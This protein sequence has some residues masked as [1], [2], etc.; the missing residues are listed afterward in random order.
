MKPKKWD[1]EWL[2]FSKRSRAFAFFALGL[3]LVIILIKN[4]LIIAPLS[5]V[6]T[7]SY[8]TTLSYVNNPKHKTL[9]FETTKSYQKKKKQLDKWKIPEEPF[10][11]NTY[12]E[13]DWQNIG[14][15]EK[16]AN[17]IMNFADKKGG[18]QHKE[19]IQK[20]F[21]V[22]DDLYDRLKDVIDLPSK[23]MKD[24]EK[25]KDRKEG[26]IVAEEQ[27][28]TTIA[29]ELNSASAEDLLQ[30]KG[31]GPFF[32]RQI[33]S[34]RDKLGGFLDVEQ[35]LEVYKMS[36]DKLSEITPYIRVDK[37]FVVPM[38]LNSVTFEDLKAHP[39]IEWNVAK[40]IIDL[41]NQLGTFETVDQLLLSPHIDIGWLRKMKL[42]I[43][44]N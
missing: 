43:T 19:D 41:R 39:Y 26:N 33:I 25:S 40:S 9:T 8:K 23:Q 14:F 17:A 11:P 15:S 37:N 31:I 36:Q 22:S 29:I 3:F 30:I 32:S 20:L 7:Y 38:D 10:D 42:Y 35:L 12:T 6:E 27:V 24:K 16:Q 4:T 18:F 2:I 44:V 34:Y 13:K 5:K 28:N 1:D 21:V